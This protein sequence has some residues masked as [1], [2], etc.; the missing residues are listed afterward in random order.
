[1]SRDISDTTFQKIYKNVP[2]TRP[3]MSWGHVCWYI[4][5][6]LLQCLKNMVTMPR[7][8]RDTEFIRLVTMSKGHDQ[9]CRGD[10][11]VG[12]SFQ[13]Y[14]SALRTWLGLSRDIC[15]TIFGRFITMSWGHVCWYIALSLLQCRKNMVR[16]VSCHMWY[17]ISQGHDR[18]CLGDM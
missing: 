1:M 5:L 2:G 9:P 11:F 10:M 3:A 12:I 14:Y 16:D 13:V 6:S 7:D 4:V 18:P 17:H 8:I 15:V